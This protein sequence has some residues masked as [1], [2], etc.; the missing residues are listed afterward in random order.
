M[1]AIIEKTKEVEIR[2]NLNMLSEAKE[3]LAEAK[4]IFEAEHAPLLELIEMLENSIKTD[5]LE[6]GKSVSGEKMTA[7]W[8]NGR[9]SWD[10]KKLTELAETCPEING[11][12]KYGNPSVSFRNK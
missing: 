4:A 6:Y 12:R 3:K 1:N 8:A 5:V 11:C 10:S 7:V 9:M 2:E